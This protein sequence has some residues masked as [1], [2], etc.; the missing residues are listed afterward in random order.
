MSAVYN[1]QGVGDLLEVY[2]DKVVITPKGFIGLMNKGL[3]GSK[4]IPLSSISAIQFKKPGFTAGYIQ[5]TIPGGNESQGGVFSA[6]YDENTVTFYHSQDELALEIKDYIERKIQESHAQDVI[7]STT[8][9]SDELQKL[10]E[11][12]E[13]GFLT[14]EEFQSAK[15]RLLR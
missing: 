12:K 15:T 14:D 13:K 11:L 5:F 3:K 10:A 4:T 8:N 7:P 9:L 6:N 1:M 2:E